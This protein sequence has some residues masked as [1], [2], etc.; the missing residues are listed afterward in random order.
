MPAT[1]SPI[2]GVGASDK[3]ITPNGMPRRFASSLPMSSPVVVILNAIVLI[4]FATTPRSA[5]L[6]RDLIAAKTTPG[7]LTPMFSAHSGSLYPWKAPAINGLSPGVLQK[8][9][10]FAAPIPSFF[11]VRFAV[12]L[13]ILPIS[14]TAFIFMPAFDEATFT[15]EQILFVSLRA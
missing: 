14:S 5:S 15:E 8:T 11:A 4:L 1:L 10:S 7:P 9:T 12:C 6:G 2:A 3:S 13:I